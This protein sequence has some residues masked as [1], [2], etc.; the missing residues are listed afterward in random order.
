MSTPM[1][2]GLFHRHMLADCVLRTTEQRRHFSLDAR[3]RTGREFAQPFPIEAS[4]QSQTLGEG[5][6][7]LPMRDGEADFFDI[8]NGD[9]CLV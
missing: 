6:N 5:Q 2:G 4:V 3:P 1:V 7:E 9:K 8:A